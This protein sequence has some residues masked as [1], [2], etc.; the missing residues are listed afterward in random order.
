[1]LHVYGEPFG[2]SASHSR[3]V[4]Y[5]YPANADADGEVDLNTVTVNLLDVQGTFVEN[6]FGIDR[7]H[8][9]IYD[10][11]CDERGCLN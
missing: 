5:A 7:R 3:D 11:C 1:M 9:W 2:L 6:D 10:R 8:P 4:A